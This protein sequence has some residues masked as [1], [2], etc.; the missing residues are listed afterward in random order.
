MT[1]WDATIH[2]RFP[3]SLTV[4]FWPLFRPHS[5]LTTVIL[6]LSCY[7][8][9]SSLRFL[10]GF[11]CLFVY[12][13]CP[14]KTQPESILK[15]TRASAL[16]KWLSTTELKKNNDNHGYTEFVQITHQSFLLIPIVLSPV[17]SN[18]VPNLYW[19]SP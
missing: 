14:A 18:T 6:L 2:S 12:C 16:F 11:V 9:L 5:A 19:N 8:L 1:T 3:K 7:I 13:T 15:S 17:S 10:C 4:P